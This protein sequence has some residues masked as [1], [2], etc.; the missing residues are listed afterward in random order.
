[1]TECREIAVPR[2]ANDSRSDPSHADFIPSDGW[3]SR[4]NPHR[5]CGR[6]IKKAFSKR[7]SGFSHSSGAL[8]LLLGLCQ[9]H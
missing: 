7:L 3:T 6:G 9:A 8:S 5:L 4:P 1:M 2:R